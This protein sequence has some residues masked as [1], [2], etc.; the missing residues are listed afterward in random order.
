MN[1]LAE[2][3]SDSELEIM[4]VLWDAEN[5]L[6]LSEIRR[7]LLD[8]T[9]WEDSTIKTLLRR[10]HA[11]GV[12]LQEKRNVFYYSAGLSRAEYEEFCTK[13]LIDRLYHGSARNLVA[14]LVQDHQLTAEDLEELRAI[15]KIGDAYDQ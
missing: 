5:A 3:I 10:L 9:T 1:P 2:K 12:V 13:S 15:L 11:K 14:S 6:P 8:S 7:K 4:K